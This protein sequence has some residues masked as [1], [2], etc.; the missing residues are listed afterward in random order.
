MAKLTPRQ[1]AFVREYLV[2]LNAAAAARRAGYSEKTARKIGQENLTKPDIAAAIE[3]A[4]RERAERVQV[5]AEEVLQ[6][7]AEIAR[8]EVRTEVAT[9]VGIVDLPPS[10][11]DRNRALELLGKHLGMFV[12]RHE[13]SGPGGSALPVAVNV[14]LPS[15]GRD[16]VEGDGK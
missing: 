3:A 16:D 1:T 14:Y 5:T 11:S 13:L 8:G 7:L 12:D 15:N 9:K 10:F 2:D 6:R 4:Q